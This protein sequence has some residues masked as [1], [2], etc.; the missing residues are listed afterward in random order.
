MEERRRPNFKQ[1]LQDVEHNGM[2]ELQSKM[3]KEIKQAL[4]S[5]KLSVRPEDVLKDMFATN[6]APLKGY[7]K[8]VWVVAK[9]DTGHWHKETADKARELT[10]ANQFRERNPEA[11]IRILVFDLPMTHYGHIEMARQVAGG[12]IEAM[13]WLQ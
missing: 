11:A 13:N 2:V 9:W 12:L 7:K 6:H 4:T 8:M 3:E 10:I 5:T 1:V